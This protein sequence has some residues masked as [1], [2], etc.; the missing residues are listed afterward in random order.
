M[1]TFN[2]LTDSSFYGMFEDITESDYGFTTYSLD[3]QI[4]E[5]FV[6]LN[7]FVGF[8]CSETQVEELVR[9]HL[10]SVKLAVQ[11]EFTDEERLDMPIR[12]LPRMFSHVFDAFYAEYG[13]NILET[14]PCILQDPYNERVYSIK[15]YRE[16]SCEN[17]FDN[18][19]EESDDEFDDYQEFDK[20]KSR[21]GEL[22]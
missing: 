14:D 3:K 13:W 4:R 1:T 10:P 15:Y 20:T 21:R 22:F 9:R 18:D 5:T 11:R 6:Y 2:Q 8:R 17:Q 16:E 19:D 7:E 12:V